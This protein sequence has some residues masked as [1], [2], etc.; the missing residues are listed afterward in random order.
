MTADEAANVLNVAPETVRKHAR[1]L[2][3]RLRRKARNVPYDFNNKQI[4]AIKE[5]IQPKPY[6]GKKRCKSVF[7]PVVY[8]SGMDKD[9]R[10]IARDR[11]TF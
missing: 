8:Y 9:I 7:G 11:I 4:Q 5:K 2:G 3:Y 1:T 6:T 10:V